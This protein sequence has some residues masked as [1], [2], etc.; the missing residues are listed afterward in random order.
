[1]L[2][3]VPRLLSTEQVAECRR[4]LDQAEWI[5]GRATVGEQ[6]AL[7]K[8]NRQLEELSPVAR[9]LGE[10]ILTALARNPLFISAALPLRTVPPLFNRYTGGEHYGVHVDAPSVRFPVRRISCARMC[11]RP[12]FYAIRQST[13]S[14]CRIPTVST[15]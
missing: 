9:R 11:P 14:S 5:D 12:C 15:P 4:A 10:M 1:M 7:V 2:V 8:H 6:G 13:S 3:H